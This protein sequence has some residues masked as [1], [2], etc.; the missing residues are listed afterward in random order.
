MALKIGSEGDKISR[1]NCL[2]LRLAIFFLEILS[3]M[4]PWAIIE[5]RPLIS[6]F[7]VVEYFPNKIIGTFESTDKLLGLRGEILFLTFR[8]ADNYVDP[9]ENQ[10]SVTDLGSLLLLTNRTCRTDRSRL[11]IYRDINLSYMKE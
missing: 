10:K 1:K 4:S 9:G 11:N 5:T 8:D 6:V 2:G 7:F 3:P